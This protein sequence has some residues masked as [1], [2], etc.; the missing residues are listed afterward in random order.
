MTY[1]II[2]DPSWQVQK[3][4]KGKWVTTNYCKDEQSAINAKARCETHAK[5]WEKMTPDERR[6]AILRTHTAALPAEVT[7]T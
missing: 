5:Q 2:S 1:R 7:N 4:H 6:R 3:K